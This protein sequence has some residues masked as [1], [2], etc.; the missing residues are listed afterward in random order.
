MSNTSF[1]KHLHRLG[2]PPSFQCNAFGLP[3]A[4]S[5]RVSTHDLKLITSLHLVPKLRKNGAISPLP[6]I[7]NAV[8]RDKFKIYRSLLHGSNTALTGDWRN[9]SLQ[10]N[11]YYTYHFLSQSKTRILY[12]ERT[13]VSHGTLRLGSDCCHQTA[14]ID[15]VY[16]ACSEV[17]SDYIYM[18]LP[19]QIKQRRNTETALADWHYG[20]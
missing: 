11:G 7:A 8:N 18:K 20:I 4:F 1:P 9:N 12:T 19:K 16:T 6:H 13:N 2:G 5:P 17:R 10:H 15:D 14:S 3:R